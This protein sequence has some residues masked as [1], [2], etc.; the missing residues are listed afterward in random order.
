MCIRSFFR[1]PRL[2]MSKQSESYLERAAEAAVL[3]RAA[4]LENVRERWLQ[5]EATW[6][7]MAARSGRSEK[8]HAKLIAKKL[9][10]RAALK[11]AS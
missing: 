11:T 7:D 5:S 6:T 3:A 2:I 1:L 8:M 4:T 10:E 9:A